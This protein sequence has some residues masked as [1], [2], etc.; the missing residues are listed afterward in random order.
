MSPLLVVDDDGDGDVTEFAALLE[1]KDGFPRCQADARVVGVDEPMERGNR[2]SIPKPSESPAGRLDAKSLLDGTEEKGHRRGIPKVT[3][4]L[5]DGG[6][7]DDIFGT[8]CLK[9]VRYDATITQEGQ[10]A[11]RSAHHGDVAVAQRLRHLAQQL[12]TAQMDERGHE[13]RPDPRVAFASNGPTQPGG[14]V[15]G[16]FADD[17][18]RGRDANRAVGVGKTG[19][20]VRPCRVWCLRWWL[21]GR[22]ATK[23]S[24]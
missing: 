14:D 4:R 13:L 7:D 19:Q 12:L 11:S 24:W 6:A 8:K 1:T 3:Q 20:Y 23:T 18:P 21:H 5:R 16:A 22:Q 10:H 15:V 17:E 9:K 2:A